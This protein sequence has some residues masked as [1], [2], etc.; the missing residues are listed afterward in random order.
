M[1][2]RGRISLYGRTDL[3]L[4]ALEDGINLQLGP[5][6]KKLKER[7][8]EVRHAKLSRF[9]ALDAEGRPEH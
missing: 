6:S 3:S 5:I 2:R 1:S 9:V 8:K 4:Q 7:K